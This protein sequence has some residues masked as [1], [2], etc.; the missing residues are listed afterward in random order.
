MKRFQFLF[1]LLLLC[2]ICVVSWAEGV[3]YEAS[4]HE[5][6]WDSSG[7]RM[8]CT[9]S[10]EIPAYG[11]ALFVRNAGGQLT[12][13]LRPKLRP[14]KAK[15]VRLISSAPP[16]KHDR[17]N[18]PI[19]N[20]PVF[21]G[22]SRIDLEGEHST[23]IFDELVQGMSPTFGYIDPVDGGVSMEVVLSPVWLGPALSEFK[24]CVANLLPFSYEQIRRSELS[25]DFGSSGLIPDV[26]ERANQLAE[27]VQEDKGIRR[28]KIEGHTDDVGHYRYNSKLGKRRAEVVKNCLLAKGVAADKIVVRSYGERKPEASNKTDAGRA[29][30]RRVVVTLER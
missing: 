12:F 23:R 10:H 29:K 28:V 7:T 20:I 26:L 17:A 22:R 6:S 18:E 14:P 21:K 24:T 5:S 16:W 15:E 27:F 4:L 9:L 13:S 25:F 8:Q 11:K 19:R 2:P 3:R 30:N 1:G